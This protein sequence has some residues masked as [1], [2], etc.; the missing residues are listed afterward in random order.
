MT[1]FAVNTSRDGQSSFNDLYIDAGGNLVT[2]S[3]IEEFVQYIRSSIWLWLGD[4]DFNTSLGVQYP[5]IFGNPHIPQSVITSQLRQAIMLADSYLNATQ[6]AAYGIKSIDSI[7][8]TPDRVQRVLL[9]TVIITLN[10]NDTI[11][12]TS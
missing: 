3:D 5:V 9:V 2:V 8:Y 6:R 12:V 1:G 10:N 7:N 11:T 4:Y